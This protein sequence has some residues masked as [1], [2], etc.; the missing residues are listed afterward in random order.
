MINLQFEI[1]DIKGLLLMQTQNRNSNASK[2]STGIY[3][4]KI[5]NKN[6]QILTKKIIK[7]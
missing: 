5:I 2:F 6:Q 3:F 4:L 1:Y 7:K